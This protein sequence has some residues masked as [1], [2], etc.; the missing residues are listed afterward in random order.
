MFSALVDLWA[1]SAIRTQEGL[2]KAVRS[3]QNILNG[4]RKGSGSFIQLVETIIRAPHSTLLQDILVADPGLVAAFHDQFSSIILSTQSRDDIIS[5]V[6][7]QTLDKLNE[8]F[9]KLPRELAATHRVTTLQEKTAHVKHCIDVTVVVAFERTNPIKRRRAGSRKSRDSNIPL[10]EAAFRAVGEDLPRLAN[11]VGILSRLSAM[12][13]DL[14]LSYIK[15]FHSSDIIDHVSSLKSQDSDNPPLSDSNTEEATK[16]HDHIRALRSSEFYDRDK[17]MGD[18][19]IV[20]STRAFRSLR[21]FETKS[22]T[23]YDIVKIK[24][25][26]LSHGYFSRANHKPLVGHDLCVPVYEVKMTSDLRLI[27]SIDCG[28]VQKNQEMSPNL[29]P[30]LDEVQHI[31]VYDIC[32]HAQMDNRLWSTVSIQLAQKGRKYRER[33]LYRATPIL[34][35]RGKFVTPPAIF[36]GSDDQERDDIKPE[37]SV[38]DEDLLHLHSIFM[39]EKYIPYSHALLD[40]V[41]VNGLSTHMFQVSPAEDMVIYFPSSC[42]VIGRSGTGKTTTVLYKMIGLEQAGLKSDRKFRQVFITRS[43]ILAGH[44]EK[45]YFELWESVMAQQGIA[46]E[47]PKRPLR[48][49]GDSLFDYDS[50]EPSKRT[51]PRLEKLKEDDFP[52]FISYEELCGMLWPEGQGPMRAALTYNQFRSTV[53]EHYDMALKRNLDPSLVYSEFMGVIKGHET[54]IGSEKGYLDRATYLSLRPQR[55]HFADTTSRSQIYDLFEI[56]LRK[57]RSLYFYDT[58][59]I[60]HRILQNVKEHVVENKFDFLYVDEA[61]DNLII[62]ACLLRT[63]CRSPHGLF[64]A[65]DTAQTIAHGSSFRFKDLKSLFYRLE[66]DDPVVKLGCRAPVHPHTFQLLE[67]YRTHNGILRA[68]SHIVRLLIQL[69]P[70]SIDGLEPETSKD[71]GPKPKFFIADSE[72][73]AGGYKPF[74]ET[75]E[76]S[77]VEFGHDQA[78]IVRNKEAKRRLRAKIGKKRGIIMTLYQSKG[79]EF[80]DVLLYDFF[81]DSDVSAEA[82][83]IVLYQTNGTADTQQHLKFDELLHGPVQKELKCLYVAMTRARQNIWVWDTSEKSESMK[84]LWMMEDLVTMQPVS[85]IDLLSLG[86]RST[87]DEWRLKG[88]DYFQKQLYSYAATCFDHAGD[89]YQE[90]IAKAYHARQ[91]AQSLIIV[92]EK[93]KHAYRSCG[94]LFLSCSTW[95]EPQCTLDHNELLRR[96]AE[97]FVQAADHT[98]SGS[99]YERIGRYSEAIQQHELSGNFVKV[100]ELLISQKDHIAANVFQKARASVMKWLTRQGRYRDCRVMCSDEELLEFLMNDYRSL[101]IEHLIFLGRLLDAAECYLTDGEEEEGI[102]LLLQ[103]GSAAAKELLTDVVTK[104]LRNRTLLGVS[105]SKTNHDVKRYLDFAEKHGLMNQEISFCRSVWNKDYDTLR[106]IRYSHRR[107]SSQSLAHSTIAFDIILRYDM[108]AKQVDSEQQLQILMKEQ[109]EY[110]HMLFEVRDVSGSHDAS[111]RIF[112]HYK[113]SNNPNL[114]VIPQHSRLLKW[115]LGRDKVIKNDS[116]GT[117]LI[118]IEYLNAAIAQAVKAIL[119][120]RG[121]TLHDLALPFIDRITHMSS[122]AMTRAYYQSM[123]AIVPDHLQSLWSQR[124]TAKLD[125][126]THSNDDKSF[127]FSPEKAWSAFGLDNSD[128]SPAAIDIATCTHHLEGYVAYLAMINYVQQSKEANA[129]PYGRTLELTLPWNWFKSVLP[130]LPAVQREAMH[131]N[132]RTGALDRAKTLVECCTSL[133]PLLSLASTDKKMPEILY[134]GADVLQAPSLVRYAYINRISYALVLLVYLLD[135]RDYVK[136][137]DPQRKDPQKKDSEFPPRSDGL[138]EAIVKLMEILS[139]TVPEVFNRFGPAWFKLVRVGLVRFKLVEKWNAT[140]ESLFQA[141]TVIQEKP[142]RVFYFRAHDPL[143]QKKELEGLRPVYCRD[144]VHLLRLMWR[145]LGAPGDDKK[146]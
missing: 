44:V 121:S 15:L 70:Q 98:K 28:P 120:E 36:P 3:L 81:A 132:M 93:Y 145:Y 5:S 109:H 14:V 99:I 25:R 115:A 26:E 104:N 39:L 43:H 53:W 128:D 11:V 94:E 133:I 54:T 138:I 22:P 9:D 92:N 52:L 33:C 67:N 126:I 6:T 72:G 114:F 68:A 105:P 12:Q 71:D 113:D 106:D 20:F 116:Q 45:S 40:A 82:W 90:S 95:S 7:A 32:T 79:L 136:K 27:Y 35:S 130:L 89:R 2:D 8:L 119:G 59:E 65:G 78:I 127:S 144:P 141:S 84:R 100:M 37:I 129:T 50:E 107:G 80:N 85:E 139:D 69:F 24:L 73:N 110:R 143:V 112:G 135:D 134:K 4:T 131:K 29:A 34:H 60:T 38:T 64:W 58:P 125:I 41:R 142:L 23:I 146:R 19:Q 18:W 137:V 96:A 56:Y 101:Y 83:K 91:K 86:T 75:R 51:L 88:R 16:P 140:V 123:L 76:S 87:P 66:M 103:D 17:E 42:F 57:K 102:S 49:T 111:T 55:T 47:M 77:T 122:S 1:P 63:L 74:L 61:Q 46:W 97:C 62:D 118:R 117:V 108:P 13:R 124:I 21:A 31:R 48:L 30:I 10:N